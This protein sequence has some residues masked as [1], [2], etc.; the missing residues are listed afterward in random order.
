M[1]IDTIFHIAVLTARTGI[2]SREKG[3]S[4]LLRLVWSIFVFK[5]ARVAL[6]TGP[7]QVMV[8]AQFVVVFS[9][10]DVV[11]SA[12]VYLQ[13]IVQ[14]TGSW[15]PWWRLVAARDRALGWFWR[16]GESDLWRWRGGFNS[17]RIRGL[18][19]SIRRRAG[20]RCRW[21]WQW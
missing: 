17:S 20:R 12:L 13:R 21:R 18:R 6:G 2:Q 1:A 11:Q 9:F 14:A 15:A 7:S 19:C 5:T 3:N 16:N 10:L 8:V 4:C